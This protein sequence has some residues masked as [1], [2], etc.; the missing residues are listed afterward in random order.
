MRW[1]ARLLRRDTAE[2]E[3]DAELRY[4]FD[5]RVEDFIRDG[6]SAEDARRAARLEFGGLDQIKE[7]C[8]DA[9]G[10]RWLEDLAADTR[11]ALRLLGKQRS[12]AAVAVAAL[13][14]GIAVNNTQFTIVEGYC[15]RG[16]PI[17]R[18]DRVAFLGTRDR[19]RGDGGMSYADAADI[20][21]AATSFDDIAAMTSGTVSLAD[22]ERAADSAAA[23]FVSM[24]TLRLLGRA[25][26]IGRDLRDDD[27]LAGVPIAVLLSHR[28]WQTRYDADPA[29]AGRAIRINGAPGVVAGVMPEGFTFPFHP[30]VWIPLERMPGMQTARRDAR[31]LTAIGRLR[32]GVALSQAQ[33]EL[34]SISARLAAEFPDTNR[35]IVLSAEP[36]NAHFNGRMTDPAWIAFTIVGVLVVV[37]ACANV[38]NLLLMRA[39]VRARDVAMRS[40]LGATRGRIFRQLLVESTVLAAMGGIVGLALSAVGLQLFVHAIPEAA[41]PYGGLTFN[42]RVLGVLVAVTFGTVVLFG[43][44]PALSASRT[45]VGA[46]LKTGGLTVTHDARVRRWTTGFLTVEFALTVLLVSAVGLS[47]QSFRAAQGASAKIDREHLLALRL[48]PPADRYSTAAAR[49]TL[50]DRVK[51][52]LAVVPGVRSIGMASHL[53]LGGAI[54]NQF[55]RDGD[56]RPVG[57]KRPVVWT[58]AI[59]PAY[60]PTLGLTMARGRAFDQENS[61]AGI[62]EAIVNERLARLHFSGRDPVGQRIRLAPTA[63]NLSSAPWLTIVGVAPDVRQNPPVLADPMVYVPVA[64]APPSRVAIVVRTAGDPGALAPLVREQVRA[65]DP[66]LP[67]VD[68]QTLRSAE[69]AFGWNAR[70][71][72]NIITTIATI[73][74]VLAAV[75]LYAVTAYSVA[76]RTREIGIRLVLGAGRRRIMWLVLRTALFRVFLGFGAG[77]VLK[78]VWARLFVGARGD[79]GVDPFNLASA[80]VILGFVALAASVAPVLRAQRVDPL[81]TLRCE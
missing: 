54:P 79:L 25:P 60:F 5:R 27:A 75:G 28:V 48:A 72:Q 37:I 31:R 51:E 24:S 3:L 65:I 6:L 21:R 59:D 2:R 23:A 68:L 49:Q 45:D 67:I 50:Y 76:Q 1:W 36:V 9:R 29:I 40:A 12:F 57:E 7:R 13:G 70:M 44:L 47:V 32:P 63:A 80:I 34:E 18:A 55:E 56:P 41:I 46:T 10:T 26:A 19:Q 17:E 8:R 15:L 71:S 11:Y 38:A 43:L 73:A 20:R 42:G 39:A 61:G 77:L 69:R 53:P 78:T 64:A 22:A 81:T 4:D 74:L 14:L 35:D 66:D 33:A 58:V 62:G 30:D 16:L 52:R